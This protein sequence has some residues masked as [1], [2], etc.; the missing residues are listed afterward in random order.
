MINA[1]LL[2]NRGVL[3]LS[4][5]DAL[6]YLQGLVTNDVS[7]VKPDVAVYAALLS[8]QGKIISDFLISHAKDGY[9]L[10]CH[11]THADDLL[12][13]LRKYKLR[14]KVILESL[15]DQLVVLWSPDNI[16][17]E[18]SIESVYLDPRLSTLG[19]RAIIGSSEAI[20]NFNLIENEC[21]YH[22]K[23]LELCVPNHLD[24]IRPDTQFA[25][26]CNFEELHGVDFEKGCY[27][28][29]EL[30]A[31]MKHRA[32]A[33][34]RILPVDAATKLPPAGSSIRIGDLHIGE[35]LG[36]LNYRGLA[37]IRI[38]RLGQADEAT[39][40]S[41]TIHIGRPP[42]PLILTDGT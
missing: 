21:D 16:V 3:K 20:Q 15:S 5:P 12:S 40:E 36:S 14:A 1:T 29:Q 18:P 24:D 32:S 26:D 17:S 4:G 6:P 11:R 42:Y 22:A 30:T 39:C 41:Q 9:F 28:G 8:P 23:C 27:V 2:K 33:R 10:D 13:R 19:W 38:D 31:R 35:M 37:S 7:R 25:L 34:R